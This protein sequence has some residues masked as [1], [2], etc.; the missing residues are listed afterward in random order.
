MKHWE[1]VDYQAISKAHIRDGTLFVSF[2]NEDQVELG[3][4][5]I[6]PFVSEVLLKSLDTKSLTVTS[7]EISIDLGTETKIIPWDKIRVLTDKYFS[8]YL[9]QQ[10]EEQAR[11]IG[12]KLKS[13]REKKG[14]KS[15]EL[16]E[17]ST[18]T[19]QTISRIEKGHQDVSFTTLRK[20]LAS[21][22]YS[23]KDLANEEVELENKRSDIK[24]FP[25]LL[26]K[27]SRIG[28][29]P[30]FVTKRIV[31][32]RIQN[33]LIN[34]K[35]EQPDLLLDEAASYLSSIYG[36]SVNDIWN[37][38]S[39]TL[40]EPTNL[41]FF[42]KG[43]VAKENQIKAYM[44]YANFLARV[45]LKIY[46]KKEIISRP[47]NIE[48]FREILQTDYGGL[49]L[50][51]ILNYAWDMG[52]IVIPL[53]DS[54][55]FHGAAWNIKGKNVIVLKQQVTSHAKWI[56]DLLHELYHVLVHLK[57]EDE[58]IVEATEISPISRDEDPRE[59]EANSFA[60]QVVFGGN[61]EMYAQ[62]AVKLA[63]GTTEYLKKAVEEVA[64]KHGI[65]V[66]SLANYVAY[67]LDY[68]GSQWW[69][70]ADGLQVKEPEPYTIARDILLKNID[71]QKL[72][73]LDYNIL[74]NA[75]N[76]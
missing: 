36:W 67:R 66:D 9:A 75:L 14:I 30:S 26:R 63:K 52:I 32:K 13:L 22:G 10:A 39:L 60:N 53:K 62:E 42:K 27:L 8:R 54:G 18:I 69:Q 72:G 61:A 44:P 76:I 45:T 6:L 17:R 3:L 31:P 23:L 46:K 74:S 33:E 37:D 71:L 5:S 57:D 47:N 2:A 51:S 49:N 56:F 15:N 48:E 68:Q 12:I 55:I 35:D 21:M 41:T 24:T 38:A 16:A 64:I 1:N 25:F 34:L 73:S 28:I 70:T 4:R 50:D 43:L 65:R 59:L 40:V 19:A 29:D 20:L 11:L 7:Y 58:L